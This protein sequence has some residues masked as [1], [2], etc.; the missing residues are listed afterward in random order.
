MGIRMRRPHLIDRSAI[1]AS[2]ADNKPSTCAKLLD[3]LIEDEL[4]LESQVYIRRRAI[5]YI[6]NDKS[7]SA[8]K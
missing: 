6:S 5:D 3:M 2:G 4:S 1:A 8:N 7:K